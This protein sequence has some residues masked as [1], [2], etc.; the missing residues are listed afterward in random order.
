MLR[1]TLRTAAVFG[2]FI[3]AG[4]LAVP[5]ADRAAPAGNLLPPGSV[6]TLPD[7]GATPMFRVTNG[8]VEGDMGLITGF[9]GDA[10][11]YQ[12]A[13]S[14]TYAW[15]RMDTVNVTE[16][17]WVMTSLS[18]NGGF[19]RQLLVP[20]ARFVEPQN[21]IGGDPSQSITLIGC[22]GPREGEFTYDGG[23]EHMEVQVASGTTAG[24]LR[25]LVTAVFRN[26]AGAYQTTRAMF[27]VSQQ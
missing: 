16:A 22:S 25:F 8:Y 2:P 11:S 19:N 7:P 1:N 4:C 6:G 17:W 18:F 9:A 24:A 3:L 10:T 20:G 14:D 21:G 23:P 12:A 27:E 5:P 15:V 26:S 13:V